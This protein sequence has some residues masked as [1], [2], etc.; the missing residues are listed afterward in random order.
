MKRVVIKD[1][2]FETKIEVY[3]C[4][5]QQFNNI[6]RRRGWKEEDESDTTGSMQSHYGEGQSRYVVWVSSQANNSE[7]LNI[8]A[9]ELVH[10]TMRRFK[11][12]N[13]Q[14]NLKNDEVFAYFYAS[15]LQR[16]MKKLST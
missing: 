4:T 7:M 12:M 16:I 14:V 8:V 3:L 2:V 11:D 9:H 13:V 6:A 15:I 1:N 10:L 5:R